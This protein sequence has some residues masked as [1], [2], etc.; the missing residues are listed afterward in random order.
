MNI[1]H[2]SGAK[3]WGGNEQQ[4]ILNV[5]EL[6]NLNTNNFIFGINN[7]P[8][9]LS[10]NKNNINFIPTFS[11]KIS[12]LSNISQLKKIISDYKIDVIHLHT[13]DS[14]TLFYLFNFTNKVTSKIIYSKKAVRAS[15]SFFSKFKY[16]LNRLDKILCVSKKVKIDMKKILNPK[17][18]KKLQVVYDC[19]SINSEKDIFDTSSFISKYNLQ[20]N[21]YLIG[22]IANHT[23]AKDLPNLIHAIHLLKNKYNVKDFKLIQ[24]GEFSKLTSELESLIEKLELK[25]DIILTGKI[26]NAMK[27]NTIFNIFV[28][29]STREGGPTAAL[30]A[31]L[32]KTN[33]VTT[34]VG[35]MSEII[36]NNKNGFICQPD[37]SEELAKSIY[38]A[39]SAPKHK[40]DKMIEFNYKLVTENFNSKKSAQQLIEIYSCKP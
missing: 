22:S 19:I 14:L 26:E 4:L 3:V 23:T 29:S 13:S 34:N 18:Q 12:K 15:S 17:S 36:N 37:N 2:I 32:L 28:V 40:L 35:I 24:V 11:K 6:N 39:Y 16:N 8:L 27:L 5:N 7:S 1:L 31:M 30:E 10:A 25:N 21:T 38:E 9:H 33:I 20:P